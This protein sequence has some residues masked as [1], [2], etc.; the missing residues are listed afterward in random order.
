LQTKF[1]D[2]RERHIWC[3]AGW[4]EN[5]KGPKLAYTI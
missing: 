3:P 5:E 1:V 2:G 4:E